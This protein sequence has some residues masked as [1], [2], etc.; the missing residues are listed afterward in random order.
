VQIVRQLA[1]LR[2]A[3]AGVRRGGKK[4]AL[5]PTMGALHAG[6]IALIEEARRRG[7]RVITSIFV[8][9]TQFG[10]G[11]DLERYPR[12]EAA[13]TAMLEKA[14]CW[15]LWA[16]D[17]ATMY[18]DGF[19][20]SVQVGKLG[21]ILCGV[22]RPGHFAGVTTVVAKLFAQ[23]VP[24]TAF[25]GEKDYQ[26][27]VIIRRM[28][29]DLDLPIEIVGVP[30][31]R[32]DD[33]LALSS[34]NAYLTEAE[35]IAARVLPRALGEAAA[36]LGRGGV[37]KD[38]LVTAEKRLIDAGFASVDYLTLVDSQTLKS[39]TQADRP[40]RLLVAARIGTTRLIDNL[41]VR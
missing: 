20:T 17:V 33:G 16:P 7:Y 6:H 8:N 15:L 18:P 41:V 13:D 19:A 30:T 3:I 11:E 31:V 29:S 32:D 24:A 5:V 4:I 27:L 14:G 40:S 35:R 23:T 34:R 21:D 10:A 36:A 25:F 1:E 28:V 22:H 9:P 39:L 2:A 12:R 38:I 26:Q 37:A